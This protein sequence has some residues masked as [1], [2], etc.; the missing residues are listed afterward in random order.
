MPREEQGKESRSA[1]AREL[2]DDFREWSGKVLQK[3]KAEADSLSTKGRLTLDLAS[4]K[5]KRGVELK[6]LGEKAFRLVE[7]GGIEIP[8]A[9]SNLARIR[10][11]AGKIRAREQ[12]LRNLD[13]DSRRGE[14]AA[15][16]DAK[17]D[18]DNQAGL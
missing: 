17:A 11:L 6:A 10:D 16:P 2:V 13:E 18:E 7:E 15:D 4:L 9:D 8:G 3:V 5:S 1:T 14:D 12:E